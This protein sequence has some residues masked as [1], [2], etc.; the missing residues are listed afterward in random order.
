[1]GATDKA[2]KMKVYEKALDK[3]L[4]ILEIDSGLEF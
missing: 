1:M 2:S 3:C 4:C